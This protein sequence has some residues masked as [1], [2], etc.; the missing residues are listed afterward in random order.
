MTLSPFDAWVL[1]RALCHQP[2]GGELASLSEPWKAIG[3]HLAAMEA[4]ALPVAWKAILAA[5]DDREELV[6]ALAS[7]DPM[8][9]PPERLPAVTFATL[10]DVAQIVTSQPWLWNGWVAQGVLNAVR[11]A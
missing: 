7:V 2:T 4:R 3:E 5:R 8:G 1:A 9:P 6:Q 11:D 10:A